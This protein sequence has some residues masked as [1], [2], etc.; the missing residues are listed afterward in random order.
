MAAAA[1]TA[2]LVVLTVGPAAFAQTEPTT[3]TSVVPAG[4]VLSVRKIDSTDP[5]TVK[6]QFVYRGDRADLN[7]LTIRENGKV[8]KATTPV[9]VASGNGAL[10]VMLAIDTSSSMDT[11]N[12]LRDAKAAAR[13]FIADR[14]PG[15]KI[16]LVAFN[17]EA[18][19]LVPLTDDTAKLTKA[20]D[21]LG[22]RGGT[23]V[24]DAVKAASQQFEGTTGLQPNIVLITDGN[25]ADSR[26][27]RNGAK[28]A[29]LDAGAAVYAVGLHTDKLSD[30]PLQA[31]ATATGGRYLPLA[32]T[33]E[34]TG[35]L[36]DL[37][38]TL[39]SQFEVTYPALGAE[40]GQV[41]VVLTVKS[42]QAMASF[43]TGSVADG[44]GATKLQPIAE[45]T[46]PAFLRTETGLWVAI[47]LAAVAIV[48]LVYGLGVL[49]F[50]E[51]ST[52]DKVMRAYDDDAVVESED[53]NGSYAPQMFQRAVDFTGDFAERQGLTTKVETL[54]ERADLPLRA[55]EAIFFYIAGAITLTLLATVITRSFLLG[56]IVLVLAAMAP[57][58]VLNFLVA[59]RRKAF[60]AQ[61]P[62]MLQ[63][64]SGTLRAG[65][66]LM[67]GI[68][69]V[70]Q[71]VAEPMGK[72]LRRV[73]T[74]TRLGRPVEVALDTAAERMASPDFA[75]AVMAIRIQRE[76]G[77]NLSELLMTVAETM[78][79]RERL[80]RDVSA[81]T[82][83]GRV[84]AIVL[85]ILPVALGVAMWAIN[86]DYM[87]V[88]FT[89]TL[90]HFMLGG[91]VLLM[92]VGFYWMKK[93]IEIEI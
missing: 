42:R 73:I 69:A 75:W 48:L 24:W 52:L 67:Q 90:G 19:V 66:S 16:G 81:L 93:T 59:R 68:D 12:G 70:S 92:L 63:L 8:V 84:S 76:V 34:L 29:A 82:A 11:T 6:I 36:A 9:P 87:N 35:A 25:D 83:E 85:G 55:A 26:T 49:L 3:P 62:D 53:R 91:G 74:E 50:K 37:T 17:H 58:A 27:K 61:L 71:E 7:D 46:G 44:A 38:K 28:G 47:G 20:I 1:I 10:G 15:E 89:D 77:G 43:V 22:A 45:P 23:A 13:Q 78:T 14:K 33:G 4:D 51:Q 2:V 86:P 54:L 65:Y 32:T 21:D 5:K 72:E 41:D 31:L 60:L 64:L 40:K 88:L 79:A 30:G 18:H 56:F 80:R 39:D 57:P